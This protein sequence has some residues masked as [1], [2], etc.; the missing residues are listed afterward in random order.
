MRIG[1]D[2]FSDPIEGK[3]AEFS[4]YAPIA[5]LE[6]AVNT[7]AYDAGI[8]SAIID[9]TGKGV[10]DDRNKKIRIPGDPTSDWK[11]WAEGSGGTVKIFRFWKLR[12]EP[13]AFTATQATHEFITGELKQRMID[14]KAET[15]AVGRKQ[16]KHYLEG[17][18]SDKA[19]AKMGDIREAMITD[20]GQ[21]WYDANIRPLEP[22]IPSQPENVVV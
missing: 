21:E 20:L 5:S 22:S 4:L 10:D 13:K 11:A 15:E 1:A 8:N 14:N 17:L 3:P 18:N 2:G 16:L 19:K 6:F 12:A 7:L 9:R